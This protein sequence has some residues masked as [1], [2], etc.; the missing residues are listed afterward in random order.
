MLYDSLPDNVS[1][2]Q[3]CHRRFSPTGV[4][5][6]EVLLVVGH[7]N[8]SRSISLALNLAQAVDGIEITLLSYLGPCVSVE[9]DLS[10]FEQGLLAATVFTGELV[11]SIIL[12]VVSDIYGRRS[13]FLIGALLVSICGLL[14]AVAP[15][16]AW[17][18]GFRF[19][20]GVGAG[21]AEVPFD[22]LSELV[23]TPN[24]DSILMRAQGMWALGSLLIGM[25]AWLVLGMGW[26]W[27]FLAVA[28]AIPSLVVLYCFTFIPE[29]PRWLVA[30]G[31]FQEAKDVLRL[32]ASYN[33]VDL[34]DFEL[35][36]YEAICLEELWQSPELRRNSLSLWTLWGVT[37]FQYYG[38]ILLGAS[39]LGNGDTFEFD[40][41]LL[42]V[43]STSELVAYIIS[44]FCADYI[45]IRKR[46]IGSFIAAGIASL[47]MPFGL[48]ATWIASFAFL[49]RG[50]AFL[51][52]AFAWVT[53]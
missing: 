9:W 16:F 12:G 41:F 18:I 6:E 30:N 2:D 17:L 22:L 38:V 49:A 31:R 20:V 4:R 14:S 13:A 19:L 53:T 48:G 21:G 43:I 39:I 37:G 33:G 24:R 15:S 28:A 10:R 50:S 3:G 25:V 44:M 5:V 46:L 47:L 51:G 45:G 42:F 8:F 32:A 1:S 29:S 36:P 26:S 11:G 23:A 7:G 34:G 35:L 27:R 40:S 52:S